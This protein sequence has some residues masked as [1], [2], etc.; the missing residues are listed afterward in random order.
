VPFFVRTFQPAD[1]AQVLALV[2]TI[3]RE[4]FGIPVTAE[5]QPDL[6]D[7]QKHYL[8]AGGHF[9]VAEADGMVVGTLGLLSIG[10]G[11]LA[12]RKMF[13]AA[14][15]RGKSRGVAAA[16]LGAALAWAQARQVHRILLGT[17][18]QF[19]AAHRFYEKHG[20][21]VIPVDLLPP[22]FPRM[23]Q[24]TRFYSRRLT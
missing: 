20:F 22:Y 15:F 19:L 16:L 24:D 13:V 14:A 17:T 9:W 12:L 2:L 4:E 8:W 6:Q 10:H 1:Q 23:R 3:Q 11:D 21:S 5:E 7:V 18:E